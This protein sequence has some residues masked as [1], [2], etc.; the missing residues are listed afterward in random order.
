MSRYWCSKLPDDL[1][2]TEITDQGPVKKE[3]Y[4]KERKFKKDEVKEAVNRVG[5]RVG[6]RA[7]FDRV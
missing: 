3:D 6:S 4:Q 1:V 7:D 2:L 5:G